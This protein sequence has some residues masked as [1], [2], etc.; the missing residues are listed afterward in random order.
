MIS[1]PSFPLHINKLLYFPCSCRRDLTENLETKIYDF[2]KNPK[3]KDKPESTSINSVSICFYL[4]LD[5][6]AWKQET[7][8]TSSFMIMT[9]SIRGQILK[10]KGGLPYLNTRSGVM[11]K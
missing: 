5:L 11:K 6:F 2:A 8:T 1:E 7:H 4:F 3:P 10:G 9:E